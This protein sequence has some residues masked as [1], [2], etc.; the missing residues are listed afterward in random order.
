M[1]LSAQAK[2]LRVIQEGEFEKVGSNRSEKIDTRIIAATH[3]NLE[4][5]VK[6]GHFREDLFF[7]LNVI[8][9]ISP[10]LRSHSEDIPV[11]VDHFSKMFHSEMKVPL[12]KF[13]EETIREL[14][15]WSFPGNVR[16]LKNLIERIYILI[17]N[18]II[19]RQDLIKNNLKDLHQS[20]ENGQIS[21][22]TFW[23]ETTPFNDK[24]K[25]F[26]IRYLT[27][28]LKKYNFNITQ[29]SQALG[30]HQSNLSRKLKELNI[31]VD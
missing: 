23:K 12:K 5:M 1:N 17:D 9:I 4:E 19:T 21:E 27:E 25:E 31:T 28:Q 18:P 29:T 15:S 30:F 16:E 3:K 24:K 8:P 14:Q 26:E 13:P 11:L 2:I 22:H 7:R 6:Q 10:P 20:S